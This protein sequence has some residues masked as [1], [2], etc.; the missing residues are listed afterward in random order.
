LL[1]GNRV[2]INMSERKDKNLFSNLANNNPVKPLKILLDSFY[3]NSRNES[4]LEQLF[5]Y[6]KLKKL[7]L[8]H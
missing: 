5:Y 8:S 3:V 1:E 4:I 2:P 6:D 7:E